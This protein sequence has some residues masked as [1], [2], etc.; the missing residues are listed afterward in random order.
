[1]RWGE[2]LK[3]YLP[4]ILIFGLIS[5]ANQEKQAENHFKKGFEYQNQ[6]DADKAIEEYKRALQL[7]PDFAQVHTNLGT[8]Y[9]GKQ[10]YPQAIWHFKKVI[11]L[12]YWDRKAHYNLG[13]AYLYAGELEKAKE[14]V[15]FLESIRSELAR[16]LERKI[17]ERETEP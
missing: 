16:A 3:V 1:M 14:E 7:N 6:G 17:K 11:E 5:C 4:F 13:L 2:I 10:D 15:K 9:L 12:N 8:V